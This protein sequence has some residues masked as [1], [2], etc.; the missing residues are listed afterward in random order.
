MPLVDGPDCRLWVEVLGE[1]KPVT[2]VAHGI[3]SSSEE[4]SYFAHHAAGTRVLFDFRGHGRSESPP[5]EVGYDYPAMRRDLEFV[6]DHYRAERAFGVSMGAGAILNLLCDQPHRFE[7]IALFIPARLD[8]AT[9]EA[10]DRYPPLAH[11]LET[12]PLEEVANLAVAAPESQPLFEMRPQW[13][14]LIRARV[15]R[16]NASGIPRA[17]RA[18]IDGGRPVTDTTALSRVTTPVLILAHEGDPIHPAA[19]AR[20]LAELL[21]NA[22]LRMWPEPLAML[23]DPLA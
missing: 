5:A 22:E 12:L 1:G 15:M 18:S 21:P 8:E 11:L 14:T 7:R 4:I 9:Q 6:A 16:M 17:L 2:V 10:K 19:V 3:T 20:R 23:D 13:K